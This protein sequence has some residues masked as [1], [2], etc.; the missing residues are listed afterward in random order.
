MPAPEVDV[1]VV[2]AG[3]AGLAGAAELALKARVV[4]IDRLPADGGVLGYEHP[5]VRSLRQEAVRA[6][7]AFKLGTTALRWTGTHLLLAG[8]GGIGWTM[9]RHLVYAGGSRPSTPAEL[10]IAGERLAG[11]LPATVAAHLMEAQV[12]LGTVVAVVGSSDWGRRVA[13]ALAG[14]RAQVIAV[15]LP[16]EAPPD[17]GAERLCGFAPLRVD[18][19]SRVEQ[20]TLSRG[21]QVERIACSAV[22]LAAR[23]V[24]LR[25]VDGAIFAGGAVTFA[26]PVADRSTAD[27]VAEEA[28]QA[29]RGAWASMAG[30]SGAV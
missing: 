8:P 23:L 29:A 30:L 14:Q 2:G 12:R 22:I 10:G 5:L 20:L 9:A 26:Q 24:P 27:R 17:F 25:N 15:A 11:V 7:A 6:G 3:V 16:G 19:R 1:A 13:A 28:R 21:A 18:G 4:V